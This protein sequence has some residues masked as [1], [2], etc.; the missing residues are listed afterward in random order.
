METMYY[1]GTG[2]AKLA[3]QSARRLPAHQITSE[4][5]PHENPYPESDDV[6][7]YSAGDCDRLG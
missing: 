3:M 1:I 5:M 7:R 4:V 6:R 2:C